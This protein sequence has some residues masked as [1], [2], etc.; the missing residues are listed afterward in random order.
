MAVSRFSR[1]ILVLIGFGIALP[2]LVLAGLGII[3]TLRIGRTVQDEANRY[4][5]YMA[6][7]VAEAFQLELLADIRRSIAVAE[8]A[9]RS[10][11]D[12]TALRAALEA[13][14]SDLGPAHVVPIADVSKYSMLVHEGQPLLFGPQRGGRWFAGIMLRGAN[15]EMIGAAGWL[16]SPTDFL[17]GHMMSVVQDRL[18]A[19]PSMYGGFERTRL[20]SVELFDAAGGR[21]AAVREP[22]DLNVS[23]T[24]AMGGP[25]EGFRVRIGATERAPAMMANRFVGMEVGFIGLMGLVI[26]AATVFGVRYTVRQLELAQLKSG[27]VSNVTHEFKTPIAL[28]RLAVETLE[29]KRVASAEESQKFLA[30]IARETTRLSQLVDNILDFARLEAG[31]TVFRFEPVDL[32]RVVRETV[33]QF[34]PRL[35]HQG[36]KVEVELSDDLPMV[37][38]D[39]RALSHCVLNLLDNAMKYSRA[40]REVRVSAGARGGRVTV[41]VADRGI[42]IAPRDQKRVF[43]KFVR[44][45]TGLVHDVKGA[46]LGLSL[47]EQIMRAH[48]GKVE[49]VST[50]GEG[51]TFTLVLTA[52][53]GAVGTARSE[54]SARTGS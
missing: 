15:G 14:G 27:F 42:G 54:P 43:E 37:R 45:G 9:A 19:N 5:S 33:E 17:R 41:L 16:F 20:L 46:G 28:I 8:N 38:G 18:P 23:H 21:V 7:Q 39:A 12:A 52:A 53:E 34:R 22:W 1:K 47:V 13:G 6:E 40:R 50:P 11:A 36:F 26:F 25:F 30:T 32:A 10:G 35:D 29:M 4:N 3:L 48:G 51:S 31:Q 44:L 24:L 49:L 2:G